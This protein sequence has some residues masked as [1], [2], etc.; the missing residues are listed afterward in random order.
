MWHNV[1]GGCASSR[2]HRPT[3]GAGL[4][5]LAQRHLESVRMFT[6]EFNV[7]VA[8]PNNRLLSNRAENE[9]YCAADPGRQYAVYFPDGG[10]VT[11]DVSATQGL[12]EVRWLDINRSTWQP[13]QTVTAAGALELTT[14][15]M[16]HWAVLVQ[17][18]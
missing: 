17:A 10:A 16:A 3:S 12:L 2:F 6:D 13:S 9:A 14:P 11:L 18:R 5:E 15:G 7:F 8:D 4:S 1:L